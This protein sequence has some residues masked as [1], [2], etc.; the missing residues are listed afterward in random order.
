MFPNYH[1]AHI[2]HDNMAHS[3][4]AVEEAQA[5]ALKHMSCQCTNRIY[6]APN[7]FVVATY[8][9]MHSEV[10]ILIG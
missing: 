6:K 2:P 8:V 5:K 1:I 10:C 3:A 9:Y 4:A 7:N